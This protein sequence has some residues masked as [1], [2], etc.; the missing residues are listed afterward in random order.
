MQNRVKDFLYE[1]ESYLIRGACFDVWDEFKGMFKESVVDKALTIALEDKGLCVDSQK[2]I[3]INFRGKRVGAYI[4][5]KIV[6]EKIL[7]ELKSK[8]FLLK[9]DTEQFWNYLKGSEYK[10]GF[11]VN[12]S[13]RELQIKRIVYDNVRNENSA[14][15]QR[16]YQRQIGVVLWF[17]GL[18]GSGKT[19]IAQA[20]QKELERIGKTII[21][22]DGDAV[23]E[24]R[25]RHLGFSREDIREN[26][27]IIAELAKEKSAECDVVIVPI[28]SPY[29]EDRAMARGIVGENFLEIFIDCPLSVCEVR[30]AKGLYKKA[31]AGEIENFIGMS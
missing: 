22:L 10:L 5:D 21:M 31:R 18:S 28:I 26:N 30:D 1:E 29:R 13:P 8:P 16:T 14:S 6:N 25:T 23:R 9:E 20:L 15:N 19:T 7:I 12:F 11:L 2:R 4:P 24:T 27:R 3:N 17:T